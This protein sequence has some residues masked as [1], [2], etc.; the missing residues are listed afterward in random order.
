MFVGYLIGSPIWGIIADK[1]GRKKV[2]Q[3]S[4]VKMMSYNVVC[5]CVGHT[6]FTNCGIPVWPGQCFLTKPVCVVVV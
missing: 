4:V 3:Y 1:F 6:G 2:M 5:T